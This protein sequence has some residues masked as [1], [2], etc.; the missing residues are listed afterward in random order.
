MVFLFCW[1]LVLKLFFCT[2]YTMIKINYKSVQKN[3]KNTNPWLKTGK[4][5]SGLA[6]LLDYFPLFNACV[7][8]LVFR[9]LILRFLVN[10]VWK[11]LVWSFYPTFGY[12]LFGLSPCQSK[13]VYYHLSCFHFYWLSSVY[14]KNMFY[15][16]SCQ[17]IS[18][19]FFFH[20]FCHV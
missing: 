3:G 16:Y 8:L 20:G 1:H 9:F 10:L 5:T 17:V 19:V 12:A 15:F 18:L 2:N 7:G 14:L 6:F 4:K 11:T 13:Q